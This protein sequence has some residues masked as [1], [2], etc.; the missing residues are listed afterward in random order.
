M[1]NVKPKLLLLIFFIIMPQKVYADSS[2]S[3]IYTVEN[4]QATIT[5]YNGA[6][7]DVVIPDTLGGYPVTNIGYSSF[8]N[9]SSLK[10]VTIPNSVTSIGEYAFFNCSY[11]TN[12]AIPSS[13]T[14]I[15]NCAFLS[16]SSLAIIV[17]PKSVVSFGYDIFAKCTSLTSVTIPNNMTT[18]RH[19]MFYN[20]IRLSNIDIPNSVKSIEDYAFY[21]CNFTNVTI[22]NSVTSIGESAF[23]SCRGLTSITLPDSVTSIGVQAFSYCNGLK[24]VVIPNSVSTIGDYAFLDCT[25]L[26]TIIAYPETAPSIAINT[27]KNIPSA[28]VLYIPTSAVGYNSEPWSQL[29]QLNIPKTLTGIEITTKPTKTE[30]VVGQNL[31]LTGMVVT[32]NYN[33]GTTATVP[34]T[35]ANISGFDSSKIGSQTVT[36]TVDGQTATFTVNVIAKAVT[37]IAITTPPTKTAYVEGQNFEMA[38]M[39]VTATYNDGTT[40]VVTGYTVDP[41]ES[42]VKGNTKVTLSY[43]RKTTF[44]SITVAAKAF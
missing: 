43:E 11:L 35:E 38:G 8:H 18:I 24:S 33:N 10:S 37:G 28:A 13:V 42:L 21:N 1:K 34:I 9:C 7:G 20:C 23:L 19:A 32:G 5:G 31:D 26:V 3:Y 16:C 4:G 22:P 36:V 6:G 29:T 14:S 2:D 17:I 25:S 39:V 41:S 40:A 15:G 44:Q 12:V 30:Y 27:F